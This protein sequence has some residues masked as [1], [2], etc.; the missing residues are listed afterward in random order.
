[1]LKKWRDKVELGFVSASNYD[2]LWG[3]IESI[4]K[5]IASE[6]SL[7]IRKCIREVNRI[8]FLLKRAGA[9]VIFSIPDDVDKWISDRIIEY[10][11]SIVFT[12]A[13]EETA[14]EKA[15]VS[16]RSAANTLFRDLYEVWFFLGICLSLVPISSSYSSI[17][18]LRKGMQLRKRIPPNC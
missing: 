13:D 2:E 15:K 8:M 3:E 16:A 12:N 4:C 7:L 18:I 10:V 14:L 17:K 5:S 1:M 6:Y 11:S 9:K